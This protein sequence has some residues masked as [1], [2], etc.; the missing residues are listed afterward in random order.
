MV[1]FVNAFT[2]G[3]ALVFSS[4]SLA[5]SI[6]NF[7]KD[8]ARLRA[9]SEIKFHGFS[10]DQEGLPFVYLKMLNQGRR[11]VVVSKWVLVGAGC[12]SACV[13]VDPPSLE[14]EVTNINDLDDP[15]DFFASSFSTNA[16]SKKLNEAEFFEK[17]IVVSGQI[18]DVF[19]ETLQGDYVYPDAILVED[20][21][22]KR[23]PV[24][25]V[26]KVVAELKQW[27]EKKTK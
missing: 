1:D 18:E 14:G 12:E 10:P 27:A 11:P 21:A 17:F 13:I 19:L 25:N 4:V 22:G 23:Y 7:W 8:R 2:I 6:Y 24:K 20:V 26:K 3:I 16:T 9:W 5:I 15:H